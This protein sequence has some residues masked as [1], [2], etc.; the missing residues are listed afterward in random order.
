MRVERR[1]CTC[2]CVYVFMHICVLQWWFGFFCV[3]DAFPCCVMHVCTCIHVYVDKHT[4]IEIHLIKHAAS[5]KHTQI[6]ANTHIASAQDTY[7]HT[8]ALPHKR[9]TKAYTYTHAIYTL[10]HTPH[11]CSRCRMGGYEH[12]NHRNSRRRNKYRVHKTHRKLVRGLCIRLYMHECTCMCGV[13]DPYACD[14][15][16]CINVQYTIFI[17]VCLCVSMRIA[18]FR[19]PIKGWYWYSAHCL[20][21]G[22]LYIEKNGCILNF[23]GFVHVMSACAYMCVL[24]KHVRRSNYLLHIGA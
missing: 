11:V 1:T 4:Y 19:K 23:K 15:C 18:D 20:M 6:H 24:Q 14:L 13:Y 17:H 8:Y 3:R 5:Q 9:T 7:I 10:Q 22:P 21:A 16:E 2:H 12:R